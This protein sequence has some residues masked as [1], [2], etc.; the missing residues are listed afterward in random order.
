MEA[1]E[2][3]LLFSA[4]L[5]A[6]LAALPYFLNLSSSLSSSFLGEAT[7]MQISTQF[8]LNTPILY[9][10]NIASITNFGP[11][12]RLFVTINVTGNPG[13]AS[14]NSILFNTGITTILLPTI[15]SPSA[16]YQISLYSANRNL[17]ATYNIMAFYENTV[18]LTNIGP[19]TTLLI[20]NLPINFSIQN[21]QYTFTLPNGAYN[22]TAYSP[23]Y[24]Y[25]NII[26]LNGQNIQISLP[27]TPSTRYVAV[28]QILPNG[29]SQP[30]ALALVNINHNSSVAQTLTT[31]VAN[32]SYSGTEAFLNISCPIN[33][34]AGSK[35]NSISNNYTSIQ[36]YFNTANTLSF[37]LYPKFRTKVFLN[38]V[39]KQPTSSSSIEYVV[40]ITVTNNQP[41]PT[42]TY[43]QMIVINESDYVGYINYNG[44]TANFEFVYPND[45]HIP[46]WIESNQSGKLTIFTKLNNIPGSS[47]TTIDLAFANMTTNLLSAS[48]T[49]GIGEASQLSPVCGEYDDGQSVFPIYGNFYCGFDGWTY[50]TTDST[51]YPKFISAIHAIQV[52]NNTGEG[53]NL[54]PPNN[55]NIPQIPM[56]IETSFQ[57]NEYNTS[58][59]ASDGAN[60]GIFGNQSSWQSISTDGYGGGNRVGSGA[61]YI[62]TEPVASQSTS[63]A[64][65]V[66]PHYTNAAV[67]PSYEAGYYYAFLIATQSFTKGGWLRS[68]SSNF[69][70][71]ALGDFSLV[72]SNQNATNTTKTSFPYPTF[73]FGA[74][75]GGG[76][77]DQYVYWVVGRAYPPNGVMPSYSFGP[78]SH[79]PQNI[80]SYTIV[81]APVSGIVNFISQTNSSLNVYKTI[82]ASGSG[83]AWLASGNY[84]VYA[85]SFTNLINDT[86]FTSNTFN[87]TETINFISP[88][89]CT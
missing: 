57:Q 52:I 9:N 21:N 11:P 84:N 71:N 75:S 54:L 50:E 45:T 53:T 60:M 29:N 69:G 27:Q 85:T 31:G 77:M 82:G 65:G 38:T 10:T 67:G 28:N 87:Q 55:N 73:S 23:Y 15:N 22:L 33:T 80:T 18:T 8:H 43:Q 36:G 70:I 20:N 26:I 83:I 51:F 61:S 2:E 32:F 39:C 4:S 13:L 42:G 62:L 66:Q 81:T 6:L 19:G 63:F 79:A 89:P 41:T 37:N 44:K 35:Q 72:P 14:S 12:I 58:G 47:Y 7:S 5:I 46:G 24:L 59:S 34:C 76:Y 86:T 25:S 74:G 30:L 68:A 3:L 16:N 64:V 48:G 56:F 1:I 49:S 40:P 17:L 88:N 78:I